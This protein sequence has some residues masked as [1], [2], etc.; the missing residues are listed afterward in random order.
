[1]SIKSL[2]L[3]LLASTMLAGAA[4]AATLDI[5]IDSSPAGLDP[6]LITAFNSVVIVQSTIYEG[7]TAIDQDL[8]VVPG[9]A[10]SW[11]ASDDGLSY[12]LNIRDA[13]FSDGSPLTAEDAA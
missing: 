8:N 2:G 3:G 11:A 12:T 9:L 6:H 5:A 13:K 4:H 10:E 1:M 7:L